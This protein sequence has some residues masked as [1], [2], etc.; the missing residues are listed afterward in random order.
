MIDV[1]FMTG[2]TLVICTVAGTFVYVLVLKI[3]GVPTDD[4]TGAAC[5]TLT[6]FDG[7]L[8]TCGFSG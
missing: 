2:C 3:T 1:D 6:G 8:K 7:A 5:D 4:I